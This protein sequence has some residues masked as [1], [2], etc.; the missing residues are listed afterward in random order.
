[1]QEQYGNFTIIVL[2][3]ERYQPAAGRPAGHLYHCSTFA[4]LP[5]GLLHPPQHTFN[6]IFMPAASQ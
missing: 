3:R 5:N 6:Q 1:M 4:L 2:A